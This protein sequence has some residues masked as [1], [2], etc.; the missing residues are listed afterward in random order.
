[1]SA[2]EKPEGCALVVAI[3]GTGGCATGANRAR[4]GRRLGRGSVRLSALLSVA[5]LTLGPLWLGGCSRKHVAVSQLGAPKAKK[6]GAAGTA[7]SGFPTTGINASTLTVTGVEPA[8]GPFAGGNQVVVRGSGFTTDALVFFGDQMAQPSSTV[9]QDRNSLLVLVP[10]GQPSTVDVRVQLLTG[11]ATRS[12][13][14]TYNPLLLEPMSGSIAGGTSVLLT[15]DGAGFDDAVTVELGG[16]SCTD[17]RVITPNQL[18]CK[19][20]PGAVGLTDVVASWPMGDGRAPLA[21]KNAFEYLDLTDTDHGGLSGGP[22][23]GT[24]NVT[25]VDSIAGLVIP[26]A[27]V[28]LGDALDGPHQGKTDAHGQITFSGDD[29]RGPITVHVAAKCME[30]ASIV[31][32]DAQNVTVHLTPLLDPACAK[33][34]DP[35]TGGRG[36]AGSLISGELIFPGGNEFSVNSWDVIPMPR[37]NEVRVAYV[38]TTRVQFDVPNPSPSVSGT[39]ARVLEQTSPVGVHGYPYRIFARP[40]GLAVYAISGLERR[41]TGEFTP[42]VMGVRRDVLTSPG[43]ETT[44]IDI[45]MDIALDRELQVGFAQLPASTTHGPDQFRVRAHVDLGGQGIIVREV[46]TRSLDEVTSFTGGS[47]FRFFAQPALASSLSDA[48]YL[49]VAGWYTGDLEQTAPYTEVR[50]VGVTQTD[51]PLLI[52]D[53]LALPR[54]RA[55]LEGAPIPPDRVLHWGVDG[56]PPDMFVIKIT[57]G[58]NLPAWTQLVPG[59]ITQSTIPDFSSIPELSD[60]APGVVTWTVR[61]IRLDDFNFDQFKYNMLSPRFWTH[62]SIDSFVMQR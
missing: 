12:N 38:F 60:I 47:L 57:G 55:P 36:S 11:E 21:A 4:V 2:S 53:F 20:P 27:F 59:S 17:L 19:T 43:K 41:D 26:N 45:H 9:L 29:V 48:R 1:M 6:G 62:T 10:A 51:Q 3:H 42:Y 37:A 22:I 31:S 16:Q 34:G 18:R 58:D 30:R 56:H 15:V 28:L 24:L 61:A 39:T 52:D 7:A 35:P 40:A 44:G 23:D 49:L 8:T 33:P 46:G 32:F 13:A 5:A 54:A 50:R 25:V 14:Y